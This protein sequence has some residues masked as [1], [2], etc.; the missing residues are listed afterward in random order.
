M[1]P[2]SL[3]EKPPEIPSP[4]AS[5]SEAGTGAGVLLNQNFNT[6]S[7]PSEIVGLADW[8]VTE[9]EY[10][11]EWYRPASPI[12]VAWLITR[13]RA[14]IAGLAGDAREELRSMLRT[15]FDEAVRL[16]PVLAFWANNRVFVPSDYRAP[17]DCGGR[18]LMRLAYSIDVAVGPPYPAC[19]Y[20]MDDL[21]EQDI[22][23]LGRN[24]PAVQKKFAHLFPVEE[25]TTKRQRRRRA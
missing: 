25:P 2:S 11:G 10:L 15:S 3:I 24:N 1:N 4:Q 13:N 7:M 22:R 18:R 14:R 16:M 5:P 6:I 8:E 21:S 12:Y 20:L 17:G 23:F 19:Y 9:V